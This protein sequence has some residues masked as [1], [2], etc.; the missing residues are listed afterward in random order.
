MGGHNKKQ[1]TDDAVEDLISKLPT[2]IEH[3]KAKGSQRRY[4][5]EYKDLAIVLYK[6]QGYSYRGVAEVFG[7][8]VDTAFRWVNSDPIGSVKGL[9]RVAEQLKSRAGFKVWDLVNQILEGVTPDKIKK[10]DLKAL[11]I[12]AGIMI[13]RGHDIDNNGVQKIMVAEEYMDMAKA[14]KAG[15]EEMEDELFDLKEKL[16]GVTPPKDGS[17][18]ELEK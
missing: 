15:V 1:T 12:S 16:K 14:E 4:P 13:Q 10:A 5:D 18:G 9:G 2:A 8:S 3:L 6:T 11:A 17:N 7:I